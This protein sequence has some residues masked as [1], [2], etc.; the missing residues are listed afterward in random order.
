[1]T[2]VRDPEGAAREVTK[3]AAKG[4]CPAAVFEPD[5]LDELITAMRGL[6]LAITFGVWRLIRLTQR[7]PPDDPSLWVR[8]GTLDMLLTQVA[9]GDV[10]ARRLWSPLCER[11]FAR[12]ITRAT[13][14]GPSP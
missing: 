9:M 10:L 5:A 1:M 14:K 3:Y 11:K 8:W 6:K 12:D 2:A 4:L 13:K 7:H